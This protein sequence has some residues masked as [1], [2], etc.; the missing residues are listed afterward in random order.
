VLGAFSGAGNSIM[1]LAAGNAH[2][3]DFQ[4][5]IIQI[6]MYPAAP[7]GIIAFALVL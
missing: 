7:T 6:M 2:G 5:T 1:P 4:E 3:S